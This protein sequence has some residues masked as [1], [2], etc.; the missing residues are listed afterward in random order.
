MQGQP[1]LVTMPQALFQEGSKD[2][3]HTANQGQ[4]MCFSGPTRVNFA[5]IAGGEYWAWHQK[6]V[7]YGDRRCSFIPNAFTYF[8]NFK[9]YKIYLSQFII[10]CSTSTCQAPFLCW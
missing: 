10:S 9:K 8:S 2:A 6:R 5:T 3:G 4:D 7:S 1:N